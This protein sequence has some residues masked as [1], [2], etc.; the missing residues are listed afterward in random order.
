MHGRH[1]FHYSIIPHRGDWS[2]SGAHVQAV[3]HLRPMRARWSRHGLG[4]LDFEGALVRVSS[5][6]FPVSAIKRAEDGDGTIVRIYNALGIDAS[7]M[8][9]LPPFPGPVSRV[10]LNEEHVEDL[11]RD[12]DDGVAITAGPNEIVSLRFRSG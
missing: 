4:H 7:T 2:A 5:P 11:Y 12:E 6:A 3:Q 9:D 10:N 8:V 1:E